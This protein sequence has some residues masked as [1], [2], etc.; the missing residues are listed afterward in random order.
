MKFHDLFIRNYED[1]HRNIRDKIHTHCQHDY[2][3]MEI[4][5]DPEKKD[6]YALVL[7]YKRKLVSEITWEFLISHGQDVELE[8]TSNTPKPYRDRMYNTILRAATLFFCPFIKFK[9]KPIR[10][11]S[12]N[13]VIKLTRHSLR[14]FGFKP[15]FAFDR[16]DNIFQVKNYGNNEQQFENWMKDNKL[17]GAY[18]KLDIIPGKTIPIADARLDDAVRRMK[19]NAHQILPQTRLTYTLP[20]SSSQQQSSKKSQQQQQSQQQQSSKKK[21]RTTIPNL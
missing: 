19:C 7:Y 18:F 20:V 12:S 5:Y 2:F 13:A 10:V 11:V 16:H 6:P 17:A 8:I 9:E 4:E 21:R 1:I 14:S 3:Q 15:Q